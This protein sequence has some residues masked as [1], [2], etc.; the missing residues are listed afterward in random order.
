MRDL[1]AQVA[2]NVMGWDLSTCIDNGDGW[3]ER[4]QGE[5]PFYK[6]LR[7]KQQGIPCVEKKCQGSFF[8]TSISDAWLV[9]AEMRKRGFDIEV[10]VG[11]PGKYQTGCEINTIGAINTIGMSHVADYWG[12][13]EAPEAICRAALEAVDG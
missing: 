11:P 6:K 12:D 8:S 1:D 9:V 13:C 2:E 3:C 4:C 5:M 10:Y 7:E